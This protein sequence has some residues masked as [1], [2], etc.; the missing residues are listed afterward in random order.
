MA[1]TTT[2]NPPGEG[3]QKHPLGEDV[4]KVVMRALDLSPPFEAHVRADT[5]V[6]TIEDGRTTEIDVLQ[7]R[8]G[9]EQIPVHVAEHDQ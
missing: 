3:I 2:L 6:V 7:P 5:D 9:A 1:R 8:D 4:G